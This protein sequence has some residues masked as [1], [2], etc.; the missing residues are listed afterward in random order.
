MVFLQ[1]A[2]LFY[3][4][5]AVL[6][7]CGLCVGLQFG[8]RILVRRRVARHSRQGAAG[9]PPQRID[10]GRG[11]GL[12]GG[13]G[14]VQPL[15]ELGKGLG[16]FCHSLAGGLLPRHVVSPRFG[17]GGRLGI[18][19]GLGGCSLLLGLHLGRSRGLLC[20]LLVCRC[21]LCRGEDLD[22]GNRGPGGDGCGLEQLVGTTIAV[23]LHQAGA[24]RL[25]DVPNIQALVAVFKN[26]VAKASAPVDILE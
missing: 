23:V 5:W 6:R 17:L 10:A 11:A 24:I 4:A 2:R 21:G 14:R 7:Q 8:N 20:R 1:Q 15:L 25:A 26:E 22:R 13:Q 18:R 16:L 19:C 9:G 3:G 12:E